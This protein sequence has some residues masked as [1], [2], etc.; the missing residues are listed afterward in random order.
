MLVE[1]INEVYGLGAISFLFVGLIWLTMAI[2]SRRIEGR[3]LER[4]EAPIPAPAGAGGEVSL[5]ALLLVLIGLCVY[6]VREVVLQ[7]TGTWLGIVL[8]LIFITL[9]AMMLV[10]RTQ[11][12]PEDVVVDHN[13]DEVPW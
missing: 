4:H 9:G 3:E 1:E 13:D 7:Q 10:Y 2:I 8:G 5:L 11:F 12:V 6:F